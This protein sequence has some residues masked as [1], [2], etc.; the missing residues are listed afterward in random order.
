MR[1]LSTLRR[2][3]SERE[4]GSWSTVFMS[5]GCTEM[6]WSP[7]TSSKNITIKFDIVGRITKRIESESKRI[8]KKYIEFKISPKKEIFIEVD[9]VHFDQIISNLLLNA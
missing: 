7:L 5:P 2:I 4:P 9:H 3:S 6:T 8:D 1:D